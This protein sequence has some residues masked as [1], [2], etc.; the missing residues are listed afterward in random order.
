M[1]DFHIDIDG[2]LRG[3]AAAR[4]KV[5]RGIELYGQTAALKMEAYAKKN[6]RWHDRT[7]SAR[8]TIK[9]ISGWGYISA[10]ISVKKTDRQNEYG[11][12]HRVNSVNNPNTV[13]YG[14]NF[15]VGVSGNMPYSP[16]L[17]FCHFKYAGDLSILWP[18]VNALTPETLKGWAAM[19]NAL[20]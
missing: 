19:L 13:G 14:R 18:A 17:E 10:D 20:H 6:R 15:T 9:G 3:L 7:A 2:A 11:W 8:Q 12:L 5:N 1:P 4:D 16:Y